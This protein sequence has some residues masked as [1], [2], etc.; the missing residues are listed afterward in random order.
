MHGVSEPNISALQPHPARRTTERP[1]LG[2]SLDVG[3]PTGAYYALR[4]SHLAPWW[5]LVTATALAAIR[6][7]WVAVRSRTVTPSGAI[8]LLAYGTGLTAA[9]L[10][11][12]PRL[13]LASSSISLALT[14]IAFFASLLTG[15]PL[16]LG[17]YQRWK[18]DQAAWWAARYAADLA[19]RNTFRRS[20]YL[21]GLGMVAAGILRL[22][23]IYLLPLDIAVALSLAPGAIVLT[24]LMLW[25]VRILKSHNASA[26]IR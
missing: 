6:V 12:D 8:T 21:W 17:L 16:T 1:V 25:S 3:L 9:C 13:L 11:A 15:Q 23:L 5:A 24:A 26:D 2:I 10:T 19:V 20:S 4:L 14:G 18:P 22:P 7:G